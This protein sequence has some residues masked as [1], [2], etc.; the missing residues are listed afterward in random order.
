MK[1]AQAMSDDKM[2]VTAK[3][4]KSLLTKGDLIKSWLIW[5]NFPQTCYNYER[6]MGQAI[7]HVFTPIVITMNLRRKKI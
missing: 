1:G 5:E 3:D 2:Q 7:A 4:S 6:M